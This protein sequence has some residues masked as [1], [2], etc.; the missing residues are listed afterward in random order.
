MTIIS[1]VSRLRFISVGHKAVVKYTG[2]SS[3]YLPFNKV[4][5]ATIYHKH[6]NVKASSNI[7][8][9]K[10]TVV[11]GIA[12]RIRLSEVTTWMEYRYVIGFVRVQESKTLRQQI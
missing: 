8:Y 7:H 3:H 5:V 1:G 12:L 11:Q 10:E 9:A 4:P 6:G 2:V